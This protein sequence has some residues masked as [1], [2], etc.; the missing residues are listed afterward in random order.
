MKGLLLALTLSQTLALETYTETREVTDNGGNVFSCTYS[1]AYDPATAKVYRLQ[2]GVSCEPNVNGKQTIEDISIL[3]INKTATVTYT[4][5]QDLTGITK[6][7]LADYVAAA[8]CVPAAW[9]AAASSSPSSCMADLKLP[10]AVQLAHLAMAAAMERNVS[11]VIAI[12]DRHNNLVLHMRMPDAMLGSVDLALQKARG[13]ALFPMPTSMFSMVDGIELSNGVIGK[14]GGGVPLTLKSGISAG[15]IGISGAMTPGDDE[16][17]AM[18]AASKIDGLMETAAATAA[19]LPLADAMAA[20]CVVPQMLAEAPKALDVFWASSMAHVTPG[21]KV[22]TVDMMDRP[23]MEWEAEEGA[24]YT[25][26]IVDEGIERLQPDGLQYMHWVVT[27]V[28]GSGKVYAGDEMFEYV[29]PFGFK[30]DET[31]TG[32]VDAGKPMHQVLFLVY[33]QAGR[34]SMAEGQ[35]GCNPDLATRIHSKTALA[36]QY[37]LEGPVAANFIFTTYSPTG[38][39][40]LLCKYTY[41]TAAPFPVPLA[42]INDLPECT[43][44]A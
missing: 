33:K 17:I 18:A 6:I 31:Y 29:P 7:V 35:H 44:A 43:A 10:Q 4:V 38:T 37:G 5:K 1:L 25:V 8:P 14:L 42:G 21:L 15:S 24:L 32:L 9:T 26:M 22:D 30:L 40:A 20:E 28:P 27:N 11:A 34:I 36:E 23:Q 19:A 39:D 3:A 13:S 2:S 16:A 12:M 41:C